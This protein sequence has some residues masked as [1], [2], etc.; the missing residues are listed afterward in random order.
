MPFM[1]LIM[2]LV[3][4]A[5]LLPAL[6]LAAATVPPPLAG[7]SP[8]DGYL[9]YTIQSGDTLTAIARKHGLTPEAV[10]RVNDINPPHRITAGNVLR[11]PVTPPQGNPASAAVQT[12]TASQPAQPAQARTPTPFSPAAAPAAP[13]ATPQAEPAARPPAK[14]PAPVPAAVQTAQPAPAAPPAAPQAAP[15]VPAPAQAAPALPAP[16]PAPA[17]VQTPA[18]VQ[19]PAQ[20]A[21]TD[22]APASPASPETPTRLAAGTYVNPVLGTLRVSQTPTGISVARD[23]Q[24]IAMRHLLYGVFDGSDSN[25]I[26]HGLRLEYD[27]AG[28]VTALLY[29]SGG[30]KDIPFS[31][32]KK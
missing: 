14:N 2:L 31:R 21:E 5:W 18:P 22:A 10:A 12:P 8:A 9:P 6:V 30:A 15:A 11:L 27:A 19:T 20:A 16:A 32:V 24:T 29:N 1:R 17:K 28:R 4:P 25:G 3:F 7:G 13:P 23:N 26:I